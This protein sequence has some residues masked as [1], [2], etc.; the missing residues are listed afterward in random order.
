MEAI[1]DLDYRPNILASTLASKRAHVF[2]T[3]LPA[4]LSIDGYWSKPVI[5]VQKRASELQHYGVRFELFTFNQFSQADFELQA[6]KILS[7]DPEGVVLAPFFVKESMQFISRLRQKKIPFVF[8]DSE[9]TDQGQLAYVGQNSFQCGLL[10]ARLM[11]M[12]VH[13][14]EPLFVVHFAKEMDNQNHLVQ[15]EEGFYE[16]FRKH[17]PLRVIR[18][19]EIFIP[20]TF[21]CETHLHAVLSDNDSAGIYVSNSKV[22]L[23]ATLIEKSGYKNIHLIGHDLLKKN[24]KFLKKGIIDFLIC[25][26]PEEQGYNSVDILFQAVVQRSQIQQHYYTPIDIIAKENIDFYNE[27]K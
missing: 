25:Q 13:P 15:R 17:E 23:A 3:L 19:V 20:E 10:S 8:I 16:W 22:Y 21:N 26:R 18:T 1:D 14:S 24:A 11:S 9:I 12:M 2:A 27:F 6:E 5:G 4:S 7:L